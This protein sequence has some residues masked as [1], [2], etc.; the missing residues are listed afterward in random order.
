MGKFKYSNIAVTIV[1]WS[2][3]GWLFGIAL[4][5]AIVIAGRI[6]REL[7]PVILLPIAFLVYFF[8]LRLALPRTL[9]KNNIFLIKREKIIPPK[10]LFLIGMTWGLMWRTLITSS[11]AE[12]LNK[13]AFQSLDEKDNQ[14]YM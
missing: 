10:G 1:G 13:L 8:C 7:I 2:L 5:V 14:K 11:T 4:G 9:K 6:D 12:F 3:V